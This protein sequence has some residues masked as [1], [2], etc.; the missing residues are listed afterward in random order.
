M[1][2]LMVSMNSIHFRRWTS[3]LEDAGH[4]VFWFDSLGAGGAIKELDWVQQK[5][6]WRLRSQKG[7]YALK[8]IPWLHRLNERNIESTFENY[9]KIIQPDL[10]HSF[11]LYMSCAPILEVM[12]RNTHIKWLYSAWGNDLFFYQHNP[13]Y[14]KDIDRV[15]PH[16]DYMFA[17]CKRDLRLAKKLG[18]KGEP[19]GDF[20]GGGGYHL[21]LIEE[22]IKPV[23][24]RQYILIKGYQGEK[25]RG[26]NVLKALEVLKNENL[27]EI[28]VFSTDATVKTYIEES[29]ELQK[30]N[31][32]IY[33]QRD[34]LTHKALC[35]LM[36]RSLL[37][38][39]NNKS[40]GM[41]NT[42]LEAI[43]FGAFP[44]QSNPGG[45]SAE[46]ITHGENGLLIED[47]ESVTEISVLIQQAL[48]DKTLLKKAQQHNLELRE[49]LSYTHVQ[50]G[51][52]EQYEYIAK[53][54]KKHYK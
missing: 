10:V 50:Q 40:D 1:K 28:I 46:I 47:C 44:I 27:P 31:I 29:H 26:I 3:Q 24:A 39:G 7:R 6:N 9:L 4:E 45:A 53:E 11:V 16:L 20:P 38:I 54:I 49:K 8:K 35:Q 33:T 14:K 37:Y 48:H 21:D 51:V 34:S 36:N 15:L 23:S 19:L 18:F 32:T 25:H 17:D 22:A 30:R 12:K 2:I 13:S 43:C 5:A 52:L 42:L 41:P